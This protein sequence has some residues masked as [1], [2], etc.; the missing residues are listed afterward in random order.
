MYPGHYPGVAGP[1]NMMMLP[2]Q[3]IPQSTMLLPQDQFLQPTIESQPTIDAPV[4]TFQNDESI[5]APVPSSKPSGRT[6]NTVPEPRD[7]SPSSRRE[8]PILRMS[9]SP[10]AS[11][12]KLA[13]E[14]P[15][16]LKPVEVD[17]KKL[18]SNTGIV[19]ASLQGPLSA[20][21]ED[22]RFARETNYRWLQGKVEYDP[23]RKT[24]H[25]IYDMSPNPNDRL[26]GE[27]TLG[28]RLPF[29]MRD[30]NGYFRVYGAF[31]SSRLDKLAK[32]IYQ[33]AKVESLRLQ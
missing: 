31:D 24:W 22:G 15:V 11:V 13:T 21:E 3:P 18:D 9:E 29:Q 26:G 27:V 12:S 5:D 25:M 16:F 30:S 28:G 33:T 10:D 6:D 14:D 4:Q 7:P 8:E 23:H 17:T 32:P 19:S 2:P 20:F 1:S